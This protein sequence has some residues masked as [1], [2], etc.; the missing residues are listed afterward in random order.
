MMTLRC[1]KRLLERARWKPNEDDAPPTTVLG[2][3][4]ANVFVVD[5]LSLVILVS[6]RSLLPVVLLATP[7]RTLVPR[8]LDSIEDTLR[9]IGIAEPSIVAE[10]RAME[11][12]RIGTTRSRQVLGSLN[13]FINLLDAYVLEESLRSA[14][15]HAAEA[16]CH[17]LGGGRPLDR[18]RELF[19]S[20]RLRLVT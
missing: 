12:P 14:S 16:P 17:P 4:Y 9:H 13:D 6:E 18:T 7:V 1:T 5:R 10:R 3:W 2:D 15:I 11:R 20:P 19:A 8:A